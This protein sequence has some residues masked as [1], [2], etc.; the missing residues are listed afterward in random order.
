MMTLSRRNFL[1]GL[2]VGAAAVGAPFGL[3]P[4]L[5]QTMPTTGTV[6]AFSRFN[7]GEF[8]ITAIQDGTS[9]FETAI[10]GAN[11]GEG[12]IDALLA[13][14]NL[15]TG[16][17]NSTF[18]VTLVNTGEQLILLDTGLGAASAPNGGRLIPT[19][20]LLGIAPGDINAV[21]LSHFHPDHINGVGD[22]S[23]AAFPNATYYFPQVEWDF[24]QEVQSN[25]EMAATALGLLQPMSDND[26]LALYAAEAEI[27]PGIQAVA[28]PGHTPGHSALLIASG[29]NQLLNMVDAVL[30]PVVTFQ[31]PDWY[32]GFDADGALGVETRIALLGRA[33][34]E[35]L[36]VMGYHFPFPGTGYVVRDGDVFRFTAAI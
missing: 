21:I 16:T 12:E 31:R 14:N 18:N 5:A 1:K 23:T 10:Y 26:Q 24:L 17:A 27:V 13:A 7:I 28:A 11:A 34:D 30:H 33:A 4:A 22:G 36:Q 15:P 3:Y 25:V 6:S 29:G 20:E 8:E 19:L 32:P 9:Q 35:Q 2:G